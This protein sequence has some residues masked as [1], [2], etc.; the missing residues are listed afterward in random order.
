MSSSRFLVIRCSRL[1]GVNPID[2]V[3]KVIAARGHCWFAKY[4]IPVKSLP[5]SSNK[6]YVALTGAT[7]NHD[8]SVLSVYELRQM[9]REQPKMTADY[10]KYYQNHLHR[11]S[12]W[13]ELVPA[14][15]S[16]LSIDEFFVK[17]SLQPLKNTLHG[18]MRGHFWCSRRGNDNDFV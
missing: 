2:E 9:S 10:P 12:T 13:L 17:S 4:G 8:T 18:S 14:T 6:T 7:S 11:V 15:R 16:T 3:D 1:D 5:A